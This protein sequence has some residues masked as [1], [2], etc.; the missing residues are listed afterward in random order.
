MVPLMPHVRGT[1]AF[2]TS[3]QC[4][5]AVANR[6]ISVD[7]NMPPPPQSSGTLPQ[8]PPSMN[9]PI[10]GSTPPLPLTSTISLLSNT[11]S[12]LSSGGSKRKHYAHG[13][14]DSMSILSPSPSDPQGKCQHGNPGATALFFGT[15]MDKMSDT[16]AAGFAA[17]ERAHTHKPDQSPKRQMKV[18]SNFLRLEK[19]YMSNN[20]K[21]AMLDLFETNTAAA[22]IF[23]MMDEN[24]EALCW[25]WISNKLW[26][27]G[28]PSLPPREAAVQ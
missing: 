1:H 14:S 6:P 22:D 18:L 11:V 25:S 26:G 8:P 10:P 28:H 7:D 3:Q 15:K 27:M 13:D 4:F 21:V 16:F 9:L 2:R 12:S 19:D 20:Q 5:G 24:D 23:L 17:N